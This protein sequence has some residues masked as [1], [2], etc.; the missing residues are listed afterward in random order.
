MTLARH[1]LSSRPSLFFVLTLGWTWLFW[2]PPALSGRGI[3]SPVVAALFG[4]GG[5]GP[6]LAGI[7]LTYLTMDRE[8]QRDYWR[9]VIDFRRIGVR[10]YAVILLTFPVLM[11]LAV[12]LDTLLGG[13]GIRPEG[14]ALLLGQPLSFLAFTVFF[15]LFGPLPEELGWRGYALDGLQVRLSA[16]TASL[17]LG[18]VWALWHVPQFFIEGTFQSNLG[19]GTTAFW[20]F[21]VQIIAS[22]VLY[23]WVYNNTQRSTLSAI[24]F[25]FIENYVG[26]LFALSEQ[27]EI[28]YYLLQAGAVVLVVFTWGP[29]RLTRRREP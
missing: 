20:I 9:R 6:P 29:K 12:L 11:V 24:L 7:S 10:W 27:A 8:G 26:Q 2:I 13:E 22:S 16:L 3:D 23:A 21:M 18:V 28:Y 19:V 15:F 4:L 25:H 5:L 17:L 1:A 14:A